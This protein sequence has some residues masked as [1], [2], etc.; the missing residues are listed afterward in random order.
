MS[1]YSN[2][3]EQLENTK[4]FPVNIKAINTAEV[5]T[6]LQR[7]VRKEKLPLVVKRKQGRITINKKADA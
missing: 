3:Y 2:Y 5:V 6:A 4:V 1:K 7:L